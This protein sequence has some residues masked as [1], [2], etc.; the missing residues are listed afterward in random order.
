MI[1]VLIKRGKAGTTLDPTHVL[2]VI[3]G[4]KESGCSVIPPTMLRVFPIPFNEPLLICGVCSVDSDLKA[5][6]QWCYTPDTDHCLSVFFA[7]FPI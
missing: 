7:G 6:T 4:G 3:F 1:A 5:V 2:P